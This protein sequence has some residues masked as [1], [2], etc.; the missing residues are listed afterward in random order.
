[1]IETR[2]SIPR[3]IDD[4]LRRP[5][6][7]T[8]FERADQGWEQLSKDLRHFRTLST[9]QQ[10]I[11]EFC[12]FLIIKKI[13]PKKEITALDQKIY[14]NTNTSLDSRSLDARCTLL[15]T[16]SRPTSRGNNGGSVSNPCRVCIPAGSQWEYSARRYLHQTLRQYI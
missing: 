1:M 14:G 11:V 9:F 2:K 16:Y 7:R 10:I 4:A 6:P 5:L 12:F 13:Y 3:Q 15:D 8:I